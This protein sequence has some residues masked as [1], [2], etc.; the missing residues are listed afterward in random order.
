ME[1]RLGLVGIPD[2]RG[3]AVSEAQAPLGERAQFRQWKVRTKRKGWL[4]P[5]PRLRGKS[6]T[7]DDRL[8][9][10]VSPWPTDTELW[11]LPGQVQV[12][13]DT[14]FSRDP[15]EVSLQRERGGPGSVPCTRAD[16]W[17]PVPTHTQ[18]NIPSI[19][20][21]LRL[22]EFILALRKEKE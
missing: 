21:T 22:I 15:E 1:A 11:F 14:V 12:G 10:R 8:P 5:H 4:T 16:L 7:Q 3:P 13:V 9:C 18:S 2:K 17:S 6:R 19:P 20:R